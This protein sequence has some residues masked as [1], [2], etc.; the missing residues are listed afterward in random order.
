MRVKAGSTLLRACRPHRARGVCEGAGEWGRGRARVRFRV[1]EG[2]TE[3]VSLYVSVWRAF[4]R[5]CNPNPDADLNPN[6]N[7]DPN[8]NPNPTRCC[9]SLKRNS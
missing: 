9:S 2:A 4:L 8:P 7:T 6:P 5:V 1:S 3:R